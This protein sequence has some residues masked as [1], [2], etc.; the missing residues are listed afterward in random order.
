MIEISDQIYKTRK[1]YL[2][3]RG[4]FVLVFP[5]FISVIIALNLSIPAPVRG[6]SIAVTPP[7]ILGFSLVGIAG[8]CGVAWCGI[9]ANP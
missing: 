5:A 9:R 2:V 8:S 6:E 7:I 3:I 1:A 4:K